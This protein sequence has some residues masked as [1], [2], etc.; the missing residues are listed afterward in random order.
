MTRIRSRHL[1]RSPRRA[2]SSGW[3]AVLALGALTAGCGAA[4]GPDVRARAAMYAGAGDYDRAASELR[5]AIAARPPAISE[6]RLLIRILAARG[7]W[8]SARR[9]AEALAVALGPASPIPWLE[10]GHVSE[11]AHRYDDALAAYDR[12]AEVAPLDPA[13]PREGG[14]RAA[15][16]GEAE[17]AE[18]RLTEALRRAPGDAA[19]WHALGLVRARLGERSGARDA[20][21]AGLRVDPHALENRLGLATLALG[22]GDARAALAEY[23]LLIAARPRL[24]DLRLGRALALTLLERYDEAEAELARAEAL[25]AARRALAA[26][27]ALIARRRASR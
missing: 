15:R 18:P 26:Q 23:E 17:L 21:R 6:R 5:A 24:G 27:R 3:A 9:E 4:P 11:L 16:W 19:A 14:M 25:G 13:G 22:E 10:L 1:R 7:D 20:F 8:G 2:A 12:A